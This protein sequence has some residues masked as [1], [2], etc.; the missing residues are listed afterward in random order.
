MG[1]EKYLMG[2]DISPHGKD[3]ST[4]TFIKD[5]DGIAEVEGH[6]KFISPEGK[7]EGSILVPEF[8]LALDYE[9]KIEMNNR[10]LLKRAGESI[11]YDT[12]QRIYVKGVPWV[13]SASK[14]FAED[15][16]KSY[17][18]FEGLQRPKFLSYCKLLSKTHFTRIDYLYQ[19]YQSDIEGILALMRSKQPHSIREVIKNDSSGITWDMFNS[20]IES[21]SEETD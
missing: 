19:V 12:M 15:I 21:T 18:Q 17:L 11:R 8:L 16:Q 7:R 10:D 6:V 2:M 1:F 4:L 20:G 13:L 3:F 9:F 5:V 14:R